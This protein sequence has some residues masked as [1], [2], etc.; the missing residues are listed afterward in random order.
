MTGERIVPF[1]A[2]DGRALNLIHV[3]GPRA[4][5]RGPVLLVHGAGVRANIFRPPVATH[6]VDALLDA[7]H[8]VWLENW[9]A[10]ID[11]PPC[12]WTLDQAALYD[13]PAAVQAV[14][15]HTGAPSLKAVIHCQGSTSFTM[16]A[17]AGLLPQVDTIVSNAVSLHPQVCTA[18]R[19]KS[20][21]AVPLVGLLTDHLNP[22]WADGRGEGADRLPA[23]LLT[24]LVRLTHH[25]CDSGVCK[26]SSFTYGTGFPVL[27][28]HENLGDAT[29]RWLSDEFAAVPMSFFRQMARCISAGHLV[30]AES[31]PGLPADYAAAPPQSMARITFV[32]G[33]L[34]DCFRWQGQRASFDWFERHQPGQHSF[35]RFD[36]YGHLDVFLGQNAARD[37]FPVMLAA[38]A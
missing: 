35:H 8:D 7:G 12:A 32:A 24:G 33:R 13:H 14:L 19:L 2:G 1:T 4:P 28:R 17:V 6:F 27:W 18:S 5:W 26:F 37:T 31:L 11:L 22:Q 21:L 15:A 36:D 16:A 38:L 9:R 3:Q 20:V 30:R 29:H 25:E 34:N 23:R 10:S